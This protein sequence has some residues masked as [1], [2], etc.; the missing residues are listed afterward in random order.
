ML[1]HALRRALV[2]LLALTPLL[3]MPL[4]AAAAPGSPPTAQRVTWSRTQADV[5][6]QAQSVGRYGAGVVVAVVDTWVAAGHPDLAGRVLPGADCAS[7]ACVPGLAPADGCDPH[8]THVAGIVGS[9]TYGVAP[10]VTLLPV[11]ALHGRSEA[12]CTA[13]PKA[14]A[15]AIDWAVR[16]GAQVINL[17]LGADAPGTA[18]G[19]EITPAIRRA[20]EAGVLVIVAAGNDDASAADAY[21]GFALVVAATGP[22]GRLASYSQHGTGVNLAAPGGDAIGN[23][24]TLGACVVSDWSDNRYAAIEGTSAA[25]PFVSGAAALLIAAHPGISRQQVVD[26]LETTARPLRAAGHGLLDIAAALTPMPAPRHVPHLLPAGS[27]VAPRA[28]PLVLHAHAIRT[29]DRRPA[30]TLAALLVLLVGG[31]Y[32]RVS[33]SR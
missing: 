31:A 29:T 7:G 32:L 4:L 13:T 1:G 14:V 5:T 6:A 24:C 10:E 16:H 33:R 27:V 23:A 9:S 15:A 20:S 22:T 28:H 8:G 21:G 26:R 17:S 3:A 18:S 2:A 12:G 30:T 11:R 19:T 25:A